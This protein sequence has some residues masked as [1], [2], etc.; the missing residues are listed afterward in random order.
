MVALCH[1]H[2][3]ALFLASGIILRGAAL[4]MQE[5]WKE[6]SVQ[7]HLGLAAY[8]TTGAEID[9]PYY[10]TLLAKAYGRGGQV[11]DGLATVVEVLQLVDKTDERVYEA[12]AWRI[13][14][15]LT[16]QSQVA[17]RRGGSV[18]PESDRHRAKATGEVP[19]TARS[20]EPGAA[21]ADSRQ[22]IR[23]ATDA[24]GDLRVVHRRL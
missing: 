17:S 24:G 3:F 11:D 19:R 5:Q 12:G 16:L 8:Q 22:N 4:S 10:L 2:G 20:D 1:E 21:V 13:K 15:T 9:R 7:L 23:G 6:G 18:F 14:G